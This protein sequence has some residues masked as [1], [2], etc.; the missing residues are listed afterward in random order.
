VSRTTDG[1]ALVPL[2]PVSSSFEVQIGDREPLRAVADE[3]LQTI[4][5][6]MR[7]GSQA[8]RDL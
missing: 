8:L 6:V 2:T 3:V 5:E 1:T 4:D 7:A